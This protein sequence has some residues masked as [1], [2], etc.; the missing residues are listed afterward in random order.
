MTWVYRVAR[1]DGGQYHLVEDYLDKDG[2]SV[3]YVEYD[4]SASE[5]KEIITLLRTMLMD[6]MKHEVRDYRG[7]YDRATQDTWSN[8]V[9]HKERPKLN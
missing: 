3:G 8:Y 7:L 9:K 4:I 5:P 6:A 2:N 1:T